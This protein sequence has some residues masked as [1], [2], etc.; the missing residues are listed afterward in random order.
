[1]PQVGSDFITGPIRFIR[2]ADYRDWPIA[3]QIFLGI[4]SVEIAVIS[5]HV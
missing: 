1:M 4:S 2:K 3:F 5:M